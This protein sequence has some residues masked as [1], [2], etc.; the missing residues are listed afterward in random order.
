MKKTQAFFSLGFRPFFLAATLFSMIAML[1]W[2]A[3]Y[4]FNIQLSAFNYYPASIWHAHEMIFGYSMA[5]IAGFLLTAIKN[6]TGVQTVNGNKLMAL[7]GLWILARAIPFMVNNGWVIAIIDGMFLPVLAICIAIPLMQAGNKRNYFM[8]LLIIIFSLLNITIHLELLGLIY[9]L[10]SIV[11]KISLY[12]IIGL[13]IVM[14][15]RVFPM[16]SQNGVMKKYQVKRYQLVEKLAMPSYFLFM[17]IMVFVNN[18]TVILIASILVASIHAMRL[19][20]WYNPQIWQVPLVWVLHMSYLF[21][22]LG[23]IIS[24]YSAFLPS[25]NFLALHVFS[26]GVL[27]TVTIGMISRV[28]VG[29]T[30]RDLKNPPKTVKTIFILIILATLIRVILPLF[31]PSYY[32]WSVIISGSLWSLA[33]L[34]FFL[35]YMKILISPR[36]DGKPG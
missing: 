2:G 1:A 4:L 9:G 8:V 34:L 28:S 27:G 13:V 12:L 15:G 36:P 35:S 3:V 29:H 10:M 17:L 14:A 20:G 11:I 25:L 7:L 5:V 16:F 33:F 21:I 30:G 23:F 6:W 31:Q 18:S 32:Q 26:I 19:K 22:I 24:A